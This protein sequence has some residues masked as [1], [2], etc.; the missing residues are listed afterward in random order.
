MGAYEGRTFKS[1]NSVAVRLPKAMGIAAGMA[2]K[3]EQRGDGVMI[4]PAHDPAEEKRK[5]LA[6]LAELDAIGVP[7]DGVQKREDY[8]IDFRDG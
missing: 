8:R 4:R 6:L 3:I 1:G 2:V 7:E 5:L